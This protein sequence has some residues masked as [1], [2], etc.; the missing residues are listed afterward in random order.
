MQ[1]WIRKA[2]LGGVPVAR[3]NRRGFSAE[4]RIHPLPPKI[5]KFRQKLVDFYLLPLH[6][7]LFTKR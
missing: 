2:A 7:S 1:G 4:K 6:Y 5:D 3:R